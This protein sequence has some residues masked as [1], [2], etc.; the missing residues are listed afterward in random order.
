MHYKVR[1]KTGQQDG[2]GVGKG[3]E[4]VVGIPNGESSN[5]RRKEEASES[6]RGREGVDVKG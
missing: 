6:N 4:D 2:D 3:L 1:N 5:N